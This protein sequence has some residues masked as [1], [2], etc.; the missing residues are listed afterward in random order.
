MRVQA[1]VETSDFCLLSSPLS[2]AAPN[3]SHALSGPHEN[4]PCRAGG[5]NLCFW[6]GLMGSSCGELLT[7]GL[8][9]GARVTACLNI[10]KA[11]VRKGL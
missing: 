4:A 2:L 11:P 3:L 6:A 5:E 1:T 8:R 10:L 9:R 7:S